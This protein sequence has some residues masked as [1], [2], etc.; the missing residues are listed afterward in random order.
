L[1]DDFDATLDT[2]YRDILGTDWP[3]QR[4]H[5]ETGYRL[6]DW[7]WPKMVPPPMHLISNWTIDQTLGYLRT[8]SATQR[9]QRREGTDPVALV[10]S[11]LRSTWGES[12]TQ[13]ISWPLTLLVSRID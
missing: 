2:L 6:F 3:P 12:E 4:R 1:N 5:I 10:E 13:T 8:W 9:W 11:E 7:P